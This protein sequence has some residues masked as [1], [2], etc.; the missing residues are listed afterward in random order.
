[1]KNANIFEIANV[2]HQGAYPSN[3]LD[4]FP[5]AMLKPQ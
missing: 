5:Q 4:A 3:T 2:K 1:M